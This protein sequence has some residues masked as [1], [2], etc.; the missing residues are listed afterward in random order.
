MCDAGW[1]TLWAVP[2]WEMQGEASR[3]CHQGMAIRGMRRFVLRT[4]DVS[5]AVTRR[6]GLSSSGRVV[7]L[8]RPEAP[9]DASAGESLLLETSADVS[10]PPKGGVWTR[11]DGL[12]EHR[13]LRLPRL[14]PTSP[15]ARVLSWGA[16]EGED[17]GPYGL[18]C[19]VGAKDGREPNREVRVDVG[20]RGGYIARLLPVDVG[21]ESQML[22]SGA[23]LAVLCRCSEDAYVF[24]DPAAVDAALAEYGGVREDVR[25][26]VGL[27]EGEEGSEGVG[28]VPG[29]L[30]E[31]L[32]AGGAAIHP[33]GDERL[34]TWQ[35]LLTYAGRA[36][37]GWQS[38]SLRGFGHDKISTV[39]GEVEQ[40]LRIVTRDKRIKVTGA[41]RTDS[42][43]HARSYSAHFRAPRP[44]LLGAERTLVASLN[45][46][47]PRTVRCLAAREVHPQFHARYSALGKVYVYRVLSGPCHDPLGGEQC[48]YEGMRLDVQAMRRAARAFVGTHDFSSFQNVYSDK[49][50][51]N[52]IRNISRCDV[53]VHADP[54]L[55]A[56]APYSAEDALKV[57]DFVVVGRSFLYKMVRNMVGALLEVGRGRQ[58]EDFIEDLLRI[59]NRT[60][61][62]ERYDA[63]PGMGLTLH[64]VLYPPEALVPPPRGA[65][66]LVEQELAD[67][68]AREGGPD[69]LGPQAY[70][71]KRF[72]REERLDLGEDGSGSVEIVHMN[73]VYLKNLP[74][75]RGAD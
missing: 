52:P 4:A 40:A 20:M 13:V 57:I 8:T 70:D 34:A 26:K 49:H 66:A 31:A 75:G 25:S 71:L 5:A 45:G 64:R 11:V 28:D 37:S 19:V 68:L 51:V 2:A 58:G 18:L 42:G 72:L 36:F 46:I 17:I 29:S 47:M 55:E 73:N 33:D 59:R 12:P 61:A 48:T 35:V 30:R 21:Y 44:V 6:R 10:G 63:A 15:G 27:A 67:D 1:Y 24:A 60:T 65:R 23:P 41:S 14:A 7:G 53:I 74:R 38:Q 62:A 69:P 3:A 43:V 16:R 22:P 9:V 50:Q 39:Q 54:Y 32:Y 56:E